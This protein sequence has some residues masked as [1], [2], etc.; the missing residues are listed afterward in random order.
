MVLEAN[1]DAGFHNYSKGLRRSG[2][3]IFLSGNDLEPRWNIP[4][5]TIAQI[6][7]FVM[8]SA[9]EA[10]LR[11]LLMTAKEI[12]PINQTLSEM[13]CTQLI[14]LLQTY[15]STSVGVVKNTIIPQKINIWIYAFTG[16]ADKKLKVNSAITGSHAY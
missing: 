14:Y 4:A 5:L 8:N 7:K 1:Y 12:I 3:H 16:Y 6:I 13:Y 15:N 9:A 2:S 10:E 11:A